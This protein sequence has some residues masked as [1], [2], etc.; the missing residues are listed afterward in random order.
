MPGAPIEPAPVEDDQAKDDVFHA[1]QVAGETA[2]YDEKA[3]ALS[4][5]NV[6]NV[7]NVSGRRIRSTREMVC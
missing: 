6:R 7:Y 3:A 5:R 2:G 1:E 4:G